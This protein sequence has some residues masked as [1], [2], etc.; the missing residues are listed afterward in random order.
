MLLARAQQYSSEPQQQDWIWTYLTRCRD[1][2][3]LT[4]LP[5]G[6]RSDGAGSQ[7]REVRAKCGSFQWSRPDYSVQTEPAATYTLDVPGQLVE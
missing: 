3:H 5:T 7:V 6:P 2:A 4:W 1:R